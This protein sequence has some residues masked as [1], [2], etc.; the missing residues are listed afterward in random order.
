MHSHS[1]L[2]SATQILN[3][4]KGEEPFASFLKRYFGSNKK[5]GSKDRKQVSHLCYC[6]FRLGKA[7]LDST[8]EERILIGLFLCSNAPNEILE[9]L[10][11][12]W[13][14]KNGLP[15]EEKLLIINYSR[16]PGL[17][18]PK[19]QRRRSGQALLSQDI[20]PFKEQLSRGI[21][22]EKFCKSFLVQPDLF[23]RLRPGYESIVKTK[24]LD[25]GIIFSEITSSCLSLP[26]ASRIENIIALD[27]EAVVQ[28]YASQQTAEFLRN[29]GLRN[30]LPVKKGSQQ[31][32]K[33]WDCCT[34]SGGKSLMFYDLDPG[35]G[36]TVSDIR[37]SILVNLKKRFAR[38]GIKNYKSFVADLTQTN[39]NPQISNFELIICDA[40]C[41][42][43]GT[44]N[45]T[46]EQLY[47]FDEKKIEQY[48][49]LQ[50]KIVSNIIPRL[51]KEGSLLYITCSVFRKENEQLAEFIQR[52]SE[53]ESVKMEL[54]K[55][56]DKK[57]DTMFAAL[58]KR[59]S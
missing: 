57:A 36:L 52:N 59:K 42:G 54:I 40:P 13:N 12:E 9:Q 45:R 5:Y 41:T 35:I 2:K 56:Y 7:L 1:Y 31:R 34:G 46:P 39:F 18:P 49:L 32:L 47:F 37:E 20:F 11:P 29:F 50:K 25:H 53:L 23:I 33:V 51:K 16:M 4:Y 19:L 10:K 58:F 30:G 22:H 14:K 48:S 38:A 6:Y 28:D 21:D 15:V 26:N 44:W 17:A 24:L 55:G 3:R 8:T 43:S 27:K